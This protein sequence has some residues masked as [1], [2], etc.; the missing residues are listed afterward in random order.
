MFITVFIRAHQLSLSL[1]SSIPS[2]PT[3]NISLR[4]TL[5]A[6]SHLCLGLSSG[7]YPQVS[8]SR[9]CM[10]LSSSPGEPHALSS[11]FSLI[12]SAGYLVRGTNH[13]D[14]HDA[15]SFSFL[16]LPPLTSSYFLPSKSF[17]NNVSFKQNLHS[18]T[19]SPEMN[20]QILH[21]SV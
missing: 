21:T 6:S 12:M 19:R 10:R 3:H 15:V 1:A 9:L 5:I 8:P 18:R 2:T 13:E 17:R 14:L 11:A 20:K 7:D 16:L 4:S